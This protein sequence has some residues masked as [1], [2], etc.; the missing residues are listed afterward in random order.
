[1]NTLFYFHK[2][3]MKHVKYSYVLF[4]ILWGW[5]V[6][7]LPSWDLCVCLKSPCALHY[8]DLCDYSFTLW[9]CCLLRLRYRI[10]TMQWWHRR[11]RSTLRHDS[12]AGHGSWQE[13]V[14][15]LIQ[16]WYQVFLST[17]LWT[18]LTMLQAGMWQYFTAHCVTSYLN[19]LKWM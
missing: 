7:H 8:L 15:S 5:D 16:V 12:G 18:F 2:H 9:K 11:S 19:Y 17:L 13:G 3:W 4:Y 14:V 1:M 10:C 6:A